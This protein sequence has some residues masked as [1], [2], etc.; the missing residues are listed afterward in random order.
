MRPTGSCTVPCQTYQHLG[1]DQFRD[2]HRITLASCTIS[3]R[4]LAM[5]VY[6]ASGTINYE[7]FKNQLFVGSAVHL[8]D[9][10]N[11]YNS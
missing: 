4:R 1:N 2:P 10:V 6:P 7:V 5:I 9:A 8:N 11:L 3:G